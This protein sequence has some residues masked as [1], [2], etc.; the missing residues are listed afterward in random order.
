LTDFLC[1]DNFIKKGNYDKFIKREKIYMKNPKLS[2]IIPIYNGE[3]FID[4]LYSNLCLQTYEDIEIVLV[5]DTSFDNTEKI[6]Q[7][8]KE[9]D[10]RIVSVRHDINQGIFVSR[11]SGYKASTGKYVM[12]M[13]CDDS[14]NKNFCKEAVESLENSK[15][16]FLVGELMK[17]KEDDSYTNPKNMFSN[18]ED[19]LIKVE[20]GLSLFFEKVL[21]GAWDLLT[22]SKVFSRKLF[23][24]AEKYFNEICLLSKTPIIDGEKYLFTAILTYFSKLIVGNK[25]CLYIKQYHQNSSTDISSK[26]KYLKQVT[27]LC[28]SMYYLKVFLQNIGRWQE[29]QEK[30][31][32][33]LEVNKEK[34]LSNS[35]K[36]SANEEYKNILLEHK[37]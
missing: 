17:M 37:M 23:E 27:S 10:S 12:F 11:F 20:S 21:D 3:K 9:K 18:V 24:K 28:D 33:F 2:I 30:W 29:Y 7:K 8:L 1:F 25:N 15:A 4:K 35:Y 32:A 16:D 5:D 36:F 26:E 22:M 34:M 6:I 13:D 31:L 19:N 14:L